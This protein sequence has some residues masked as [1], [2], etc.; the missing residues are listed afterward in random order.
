MDPAVVT[1]AKTLVVATQCGVTTVG[2]HDTERLTAGN[3]ADM[4]R[5]GLDQ[6][7]FVPVSHTDEL[8]GHLVCSE[9]DRP[10]LLAVGLRW[11]A[12]R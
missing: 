8:I 4:T 10:S 1:T 12:G 7:T 9:S 6:R 11:P 3:I 5:I 2:L